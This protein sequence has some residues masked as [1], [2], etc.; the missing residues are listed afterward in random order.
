M[1]KQGIK[2]MVYDIEELLRELCLFA[3]MLEEKCL[4][5]S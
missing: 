5:K 3:V 1:M 4:Y 2:H